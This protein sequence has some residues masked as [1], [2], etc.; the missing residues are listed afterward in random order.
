MSELLK[1]VPLG[2]IAAGVIAS[3]STAQMQ[4]N[5]HEQEL[6]EK[7]TLEQFRLMVRELESASESIDENEEGIEAIQRLLIQR[8]GD[9]ELKLFRVESEQK[10]QGA[11]LDQI[12][13][14]LQGIQNGN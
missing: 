1:F 5:D 12:L 9:V 7:A 3:A 11:D 13:T 2:V 8:Q 4:I 6:N 14:I 10:A